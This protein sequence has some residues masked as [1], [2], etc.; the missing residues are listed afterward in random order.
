MQTDPEGYG[1]IK[2]VLFKDFSRQLADVSVGV[3]ACIISWIIVDEAPPLLKLRRQIQ[4]SVSVGLT[5]LVANS[6]TGNF[7]KHSHTIK[8]CIPFY[9]KTKKS[10]YKVFNPKKFCSEV[11]Q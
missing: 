8:V 4:T 6:I 1:S 11:Q 10:R 5:V 9:K 2:I 7:I 3:T